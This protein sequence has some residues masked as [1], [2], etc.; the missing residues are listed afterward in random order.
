MSE[1]PDPQPDSHGG[2]H[3]ASAM[4][5][6]DLA[7]RIGSRFAGDGPEISR[8]Q[9]PKKT[10][11]ENPLFENGIDN[12]LPFPFEPRAILTRP[13]SRHSQGRRTRLPSERTRARS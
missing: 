4:I 7:V 13:P 10:T 3:A 1:Q 5:D 12:H 9:E 2:R 8:A 11:L 6:W